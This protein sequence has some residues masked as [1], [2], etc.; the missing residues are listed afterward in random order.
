L[1]DIDGKM[2]VELTGDEFF[3]RPQD[4]RRELFIE[5]AEFQVGLRRRGFDQAQGA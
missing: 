2:G 3:G 5:P 4:Q 1:E